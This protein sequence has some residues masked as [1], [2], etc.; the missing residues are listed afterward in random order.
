MKVIK[1][2]VEHWNTKIPHK[3]IFSRFYHKHTKGKIT[4]TIVLKGYKKEI[5]KTFNA[6]NNSLQYQGES[7]YKFKNKKIEQKYQQWY[8]SLDESIKFKIFYGDKIPD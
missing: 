3:T 6:I 4:K 5:F 2:K 8:E 1:V 7:F